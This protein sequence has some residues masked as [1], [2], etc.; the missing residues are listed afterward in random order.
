[1]TVSAYPRYSIGEILAL[2]K[3]TTCVSS[4]AR[5]YVERPRQSP[6]DNA[7]VLGHMSGCAYEYMRAEKGVGCMR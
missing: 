2:A 6:R 4:R 7:C 3:R 1:M 5:A